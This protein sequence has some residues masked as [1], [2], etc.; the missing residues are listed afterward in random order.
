VE[1]DEEG[2]AIVVARED[3]CRHNAMFGFSFQQIPPLKNLFSRD[4]N[5]CFPG[6]A[7]VGPGVLC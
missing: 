5:L 4:K 6:L 7:A 3:L 2:A 1:G